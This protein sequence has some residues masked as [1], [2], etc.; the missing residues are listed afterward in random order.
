MIR[1]IQNKY[2]SDQSLP[3]INDKTIVVPY[4]NVNGID[5][6]NRPGNEGCA[7][8]S[9]GWYQNNFFYDSID[10]FNGWDLSKLAMQRSVPD[11]AINNEIY[12]GSCYKGSA[13]NTPDPKFHILADPSQPNWQALV[14][15]TIRKK[16]LI[17]G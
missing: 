4:I 2:R 16:Y 10:F 14:L 11:A 5:F 3:L 8:G 1:A 17:S 7:V 12:Y 15:P 9:H 6:S 13:T